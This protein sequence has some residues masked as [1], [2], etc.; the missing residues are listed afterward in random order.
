MKKIWALSLVILLSSCHTMMEATSLSAPTIGSYQS[1]ENQKG[2][3]IY[4][5]SQPAYS[6]PVTPGIAISPAYSYS[7]SEES[8]SS[9]SA[10]SSL[11]SGNSGINGFIEAAKDHDQFHMGIHAGGFMD[12]DVLMPRGGLSFFSSGSE[13]YWGF[14]VSMRAYYRTE[15]IQP[16]LGLGGYG[17][18]TKKCYYQN[19]GTGK[20]EQI[21]E[22]NFLYAGFA[23]V[24]LH[25]QWFEIFWR[26]YNISRAGIQVPSE[27][28]WGI[29][30][31]F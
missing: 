19:S 17:G 21:C 7:S 11:F 9:S 10:T 6:A 31:V 1:T 25:Y 29:G 5:S 15:S 28:S 4:R 30:I 16:F 12:N 20:L 24:G 8:A 3:T 26:D 2:E 23:E 14:D 18:D 22:K 13:T 27:S